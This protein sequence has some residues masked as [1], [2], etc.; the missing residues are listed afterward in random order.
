MKVLVKDWLLEDLVLQVNNKN[1]NFDKKDL[2][3]KFIAHFKIFQE[4]NYY[5]DGKICK[6][7]DWNVF[8]L[9]IQLPN[10]FLLRWLFAFEKGIICIYGAYILK[11]TNYF[12][13]K[14]K[15]QIEKEYKEK[16]LIIKNEYTDYKNSKL[17]NYIDI[18]DL[19]NKY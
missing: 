11:P 9:R 2:I 5:P 19:I 6:N 16:I 17:K 15:K 3:K 18:T 12:K 1:I 8:E 13:K 7:L 4:N 10:N 14:D